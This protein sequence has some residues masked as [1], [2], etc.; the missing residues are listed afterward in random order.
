[1]TGM[2]NRLQEIVSEHAE[3]IGVPGV[4]AGVYL[5]GT[6]E[7]A[8]HGVTS[9][10]NPLPVDENTLFQFGS[11]GKTFTST[12]IMR[13]VEAGKID[14]HAP[15]RRYVPELVLADESTAEAVT[16]LNLLN[17]TAGWSGDYLGSAQDMGDDALANY[18]TQMATLPQEY[19]LGAGVSY[20]NA[21]LSLA[22]RVIEKVTGQRFEDAIAELILRPLGMD[23]SYFFLTD[24][25]TRRFV[26]GHT[27]G[28]D[29]AFTVARPWAM[30]RSG[31]P[32]GG[33]TANAGDQVAWIRFH[34]GD[35]TAPDGTRLLTRET[36][37]QM[38]QPTVDMVGS[39]IGD[40]VGISWLIEDVDGVRLVG[41]GGSTI[42]QQSAFQ[43]VPERKFGIAVLTNADAGSDLNHAVVRAALK[44]YIGVVQTDPE[45]TKRETAALA[46][47]AGDYDTIAMSLKLT[48]GEDG[49]LMAD[50]QPKPEFLAQLG[51]NAEDF[52]S[53]PM[54]LGMTTPDGD[55]F[56][57]V[58]GPGQG[59][60]GYFARDDAGKISAVHLGGRLATRI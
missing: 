15:V 4:A 50:S 35:G 36:L 19:P 30:P 37:E 11:T 40:H 45:P 58:E 20:N 9:V 23:H 1:M 21:S 46:E 48:V 13:L 2:T 41:H 32:A 56:V 44:E 59:M 25:M 43:M 31:A 54:P 55:G 38:K 3:R 39:A 27:K 8:F 52:A 14:L 60:K 24:I 5:D 57:I 28:D 51:A 17:H 6:E 34:L 10:E 12:A 53:P 47:F 7:Y 42:G 18:V 16:V 49:W 29:G 26:V 22:G 33:I